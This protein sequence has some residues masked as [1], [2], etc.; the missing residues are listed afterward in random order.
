MLLDRAVHLERV[1]AAG[2]PAVKLLK[3]VDAGDF[4]G[5][6]VKPREF[7]TEGWEPRGSVT[8]LTGVGASG[9][10]LLT[11]QRMT[12]SAAGLSFL[13]IET[14]PGVSIYL[15]CEDDMD[16][17]QRRQES[18]NAA[19]GITWDDLRG[20]LYLVSN[21]GELNNEFCTFDS[22]NRMR[23][24]DRWTET[25]ATIH[26]LG[27]THIALDNV[28]HLFTGNENIRNHVAAFTGLLDRLAQEINGGVL[29]LGHPNKAGAEFSGST[30]WENQVRARIYLALDKGDDGEVIDP[31]ARILTASK[32]NYSRRG[33]SIAFRWH[34]WAFI[35]EGDMPEDQ[36]RE[37]AATLQASHD[38]E[39]FLRCLR[40]MTRRQ[41]A[42]SDNLASRTYAPLIF[43]K[44]PEAKGIGKA[45]LEEAMDRL[46]RVNAIERGFLWRADRKDRFGL[47]EKCADPCADPA[48]TGCADPAPT[49]RR[50]AFS[51]TPY[52][53]YRE[54]AAPQAVAPTPLDPDHPD[55]PDANSGWSDEPN[56]NR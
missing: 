28:A 16:E 53:T 15:T 42:V 22:D 51:H 2:G 43:S 32:P 50:P 13:G 39:L 3:Y 17:I 1:E 40:E 25:L 35:Q 12:C 18:I 30:A 37:L 45:R 26:A 5:V 33:S 24:T 21:K 10:S 23:T 49:P 27:A 4:A 54:G 31:D 46:Y 47:R 44:M 29:L 19:L 8:Y 41:Q 36:R 38:N 7:M 20:R 52:T 14:R 6:P 56:S 55:A 9:K 11:Q 34:Q 48:L